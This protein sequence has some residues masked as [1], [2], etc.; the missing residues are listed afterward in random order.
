MPLIN[1]LNF[2]WYLLL[3]SKYDERQH[4]SVVIEIRMP[5]E[6]DQKKRRISQTF[7]CEHRFGTEWNR[8]QNRSIFFGEMKN[9]AS[10]FSIIK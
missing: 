6:K 9:T 5:V 1:E 4:H 10:W 3:E 8:D 7:W 2:N